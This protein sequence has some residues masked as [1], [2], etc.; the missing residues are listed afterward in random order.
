MRV[1]KAGQ[2]IDVVLY[3]LDRAYCPPGLSAPVGGSEVE[4]YQLR[5]AFL[6]AGLSCE[7]VLGPPA[8]NYGECGTLIYWRQVE[9]VTWCRPKRSIVR[10]TDALPEGCRQPDD[11]LTVCVSKWQAARFASPTV[12]V[13]PMLG[14]HVYRHVS[15]RII[16]PTAWVYASA[17]NK[18]LRETLTAW[19]KGP[20]G[21]HPL[22]VTTTGYD[23]PEVGLCESYNARWLGR[24]GPLDMVDL[25]ASCHGMFYRNAA[26]ETFGV[27]TAI[28]VAL[29]LELNIECVGHDACGL[30]ESRVAQDLSEKATVERWLRV[31]NA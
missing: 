17:A 30:A 29:G 28:A 7:L 20:I 13:P 23:E 15:D 8:E 6:R 18:G 5:D 27:T 9:P 19:E 25:I 22:M 1:Q 10:S 31:L 11:I 4:L 3:D 14:D 21:H 2:V 12:V 26:P 24:L 16:A